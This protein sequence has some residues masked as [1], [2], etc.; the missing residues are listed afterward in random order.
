MAIQKPT[1]DS[2]ANRVPKVRIARPAGRPFQLR[3]KVPKPKKKSAFLLNRET[4]PKLNDK[5]INSK[6]S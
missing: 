1:R 3:Y 5:R 2:S 6:P 4:N